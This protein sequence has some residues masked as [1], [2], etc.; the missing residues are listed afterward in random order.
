[1]DDAE[2]V[3]RQSELRARVRW[4]QTFLQD[5]MLYL[6]LGAVIAGSGL[7]MW[8]MDDRSERL[9]AVVAAERSRAAA[10]P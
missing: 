4:R 10:C 5:A 7:V 2:W 8:R 9:F 3:R 6:F 1:V